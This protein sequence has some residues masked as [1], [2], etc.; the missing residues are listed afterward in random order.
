MV[1]IDHGN[2]IV[3]RY[4]HLARMLVGVGVH[5]EAGQTVG[6]VGR[7]GTHTSGP[8]LH[9]EVLEHGVFQDPRGYLG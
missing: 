1:R 7:T 2:G 6:T 3:T 9:Y 5:V 4:A 8:H